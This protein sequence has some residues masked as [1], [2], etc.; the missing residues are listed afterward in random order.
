[1][2]AANPPLASTPGKIEVVE[3]F[4]YGCP[5]CYAC[6]PAIEEWSKR[7][8]NDVSFRKVHVPKRRAA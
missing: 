4:W 2:E 7:L 5:H 1:M 3:F 8:P 6:E